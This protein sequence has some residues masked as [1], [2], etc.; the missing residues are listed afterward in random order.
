MNKPAAEIA[1][2]LGENAEAVCRRYL[3]KGRREGQ[4][5][6]VGNIR[7]DPGR[8]LYV[9]LSGDAEGGR[10]AGKWTDAQSGDHGD[11]LDIIAATCGHASFR[12]TMDE[13]RRFLSLP[14][15]PPL[16]RNPAPRK[17]SPGSPEAARQ[18][19]AALKPLP[20]SLADAYLQGRR[21]V[22]SLA[23]DSLRFHPRCY[24]RASEDDP[25]NIRPAWPALIAAVTD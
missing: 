10:S 13:A 25:P 6:M 18:L 23:A 11:L 2:R 24:Y 9:R 19:W 15:D 1:R 14:I 20:G 4:Y 21:I 12:D 8:S 22:S 17:Y 5:W 3:N 16:A 7:I